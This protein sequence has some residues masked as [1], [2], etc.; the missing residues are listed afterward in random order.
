MA[1]AGKL[2]ERPAIHHPVL[3]SK[4]ALPVPETVDRDHAVGEMVSVR[5]LMEANVEL[6]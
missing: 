4:V 1:E 6:V 2:R 3:N 5:W